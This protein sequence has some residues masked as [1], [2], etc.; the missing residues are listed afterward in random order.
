MYII[1]IPLS[2][3]FCT[4]IYLCY[5]GVA[6]LFDVFSGAWNMRGRT[7]YQGAI[8]ESWGLVVYGGRIQ[9]NQI[10]KFQACLWRAA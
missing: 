5:L 4:V 10:D 8:I 3:F 2:S 1:C 7:L 6:Y 9:R